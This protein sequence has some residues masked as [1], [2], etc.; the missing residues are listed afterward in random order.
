MLII[1]SCSHNG[2]Y[3]KSHIVSNAGY[4]NT[5]KQAVFE[6]TDARSVHGPGKIQQLGLKRE[7]N[8]F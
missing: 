7:M 3:K 4:I 1:L 6:S 5:Q 2:I 8:Y